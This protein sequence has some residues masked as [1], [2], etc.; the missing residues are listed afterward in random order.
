[1]PQFWFILSSIFQTRSSALFAAL[2]AALRTGFCFGI[3]ITATAP[4]A[5]PR[6]AV[7]AHPFMVMSI[8]PFGVSMPRKK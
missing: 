3:I 1:M 2:A 5:A 7:I 6:P 4:A 8:T